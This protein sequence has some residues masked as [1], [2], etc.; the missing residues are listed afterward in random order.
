MDT[1][2]KLVLF[3][4]ISIVK[5]LRLSMFIPTMYYY[6]L[7]IFH[8]DAIKANAFKGYVSATYAIGGILGKSFSFLIAL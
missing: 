2:K 1:N 6:F 5:G 8:N 4:M 3:S 7:D